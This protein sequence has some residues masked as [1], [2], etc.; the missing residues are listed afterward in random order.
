MKKKIIVQGCLGAI[1]GVSISFIIPLFISMVIGDGN[2]YPVALEMQEVYKTQLGAVQIQVVLS[3]LYGTVWGIAPLVF[4]VERWSLL[5]QTITHLALTS[6]STFPVA[7]LC[8]WM[9][10]NFESIFIYFA[11][12]FFIYVMIWIFSYMMIRNNIKEMNRK[13][14]SI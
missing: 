2:Y 10:H 5:R 13:I 12:F 7:Y 14:K 6:L 11:V 3:L 9:N 8:F 1:I 4:Q